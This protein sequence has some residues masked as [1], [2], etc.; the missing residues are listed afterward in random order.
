MD[1]QYVEFSGTDFDND[2]DSVH[3]PDPNA[4]I[5]NKQLN[6]SL[7]NLLV[8]K[9]RRLQEDLTKLRV[10]WEDLST[11]HA[12]AE[13]NLENLESELAQVKELNERLENDLLSV[14]KGDGELS[15]ETR[16]GSITPAQGL[17]GLDLGGKAAV[18]F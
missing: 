4:E 3:L 15:R 16:G 10:A 9:N 18:S 11:R 12:K 7:E 13:D 6:R 17:A 5:A 2:D 1:P 14:N 8:I